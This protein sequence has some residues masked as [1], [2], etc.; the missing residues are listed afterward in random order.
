MNSPFLDERDSM[1]QFDLDIPKLQRMLL[2]FQLSILEK[3]DLPPSPYGGS[4]SFAYTL[5]L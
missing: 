3:L 4:R 2:Y 1:H 5:I